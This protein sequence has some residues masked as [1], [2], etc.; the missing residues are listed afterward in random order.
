MSNNDLGRWIER[1]LNRRNW[2]Q[3]ELA[4]QSGLHQSHI[5]RIINAP[6]G[7]DGPVC[8][9]RAAQ[10][11]ADAFEASPAYVLRLARITKPPPRSRNFSTWL[12]GDLLAKGLSQAELAGQSGLPQKVIAGFTRGV[13]P[14]VEQIQ[15]LAGPL[16]MP[17]SQLAEIAGLEVPN[18]RST[19]DE[20]ELLEKYR[21]LSPKQQ[22][23]LQAML[24]VIKE[25]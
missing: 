2:S 10:A 19:E 22:K 8:G 24:A 14:T 12:L 21:E 5:S 3:S 1:E 20:I 6:A 15:A 23:L 11:I 13:L 16:E 7:D 4:R 25:H 17:A 9:R 18:L